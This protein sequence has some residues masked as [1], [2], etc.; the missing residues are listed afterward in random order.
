MLLKVIFH[1][2]QKLLDIHPGYT[3][4]RNRKKQISWEKST[5]NYYRSE[6]HPYSNMLVIVC[7]VVFVVVCLVVVIVFLFV[8]VCCFWFWLFVYLILCL[9]FPGEGRSGSIPFGPGLPLFFSAVEDVA[10]G[11]CCGGFQQ[12]NAQWEHFKYDEISPFFLFCVLKTPDR[13]KK[14]LPFLK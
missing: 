10:K 14:T 5:Y 13:N 4:W 12:N 3:L 6:L 11:G 7:F 1:E 8:Y 2:S 9:S